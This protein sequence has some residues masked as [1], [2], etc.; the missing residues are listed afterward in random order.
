MR[1]TLS[2]VAA[3]LALAASTGC[4]DDEP[5]GGEG[6]RGAA[7][8]P[9]ATTAP[10]TATRPD[11]PPDQSRWASQV[12]AA[13]RPVQQQIDAL[14]PP[15]DAASLETWVEQV[16]PLARK[17]V[18]AVKAVKPSVKE[19]E[20]RKAKLFIESLQG[21]ER[22]LT[23]YL[24]ALRKGNTAAIEEALKEA[25]AAGAQARAY[26]ISLELTEC[27]GYSGG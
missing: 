6:T 21:I 24:A 13:C 19:D 18:A 10:E 25:N 9:A 23:S 8:E 2:V 16:L 7:S 27:G 14:A 12:D 4:G 15:T 5:S 17:Q 1:S 26:A 11:A 22:G 20:L 3:S